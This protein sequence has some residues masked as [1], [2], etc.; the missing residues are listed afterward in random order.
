MNLTPFMEMIASGRWLNDS[1]ELRPLPLAGVPG[2]RQD[3]ADEAFHRTTRVPA[4]PRGR[5]YPPAW[6]LPDWRPVG[7]LSALCPP[8][9]GE[10]AG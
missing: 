5:Q 10:G 8:N 2:W 6:C 9:A 1:M 7:I 3:N 4:S